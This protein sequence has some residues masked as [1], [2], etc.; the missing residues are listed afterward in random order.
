MTPDRCPFCESDKTWIWDKGV[1]GKFAAACSNPGC[2]ATG[3]IAATERAAVA[4]WNAAPR[5]VDRSRSRVRTA[6]S[7]P[8]FDELRVQE[9]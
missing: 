1:P 8:T 5:D 2:A 3:P 4:S 9:R 7:S 6:A